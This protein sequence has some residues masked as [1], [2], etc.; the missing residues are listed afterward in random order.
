MAGQW[1]LISVSDYRKCTSQQRRDL[2][3]H[4][5]SVQYL[6]PC[7]VGWSNMSWLCRQ[8]S[9]AGHTDAVTQIKHPGP[10]VRLPRTY[11]LTI[12]HFNITGA[13]FL[14]FLLLIIWTIFKVKVM[15]LMIFVIKSPT[16]NYQRL[17]QWR[18]CVPPLSKILFLRQYQLEKKQKN[19]QW[20]F[21]AKMQS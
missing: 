21:N 7:L 6:H 17:F 16:H 2:A 18:W 5:C 20:W 14:L 1:Q 12:F 10:G 3:A 19:R 15:I 9:W 11:I 4:G 13:V 8:T